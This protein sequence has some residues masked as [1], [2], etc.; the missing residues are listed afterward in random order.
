[1][2]L[3]NDYRLEK[4]DEMNLVLQKKMIPETGKKKGQEQWKNIRY[5]P[6]YEVALTDVVELSLFDVGIEDD[7]F[8]LRAKISELKSLYMRLGKTMDERSMR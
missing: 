3:T 1:M 4:L 2:K 5:Y 7:L 8:Q 6:S